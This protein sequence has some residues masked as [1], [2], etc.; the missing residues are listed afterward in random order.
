M[1][2]ASDHLA[3]IP[4][5]SG[6][7]DSALE[8]VA[9]L[10]TPA[11]VQ[12]GHVLVEHGQA[13]SGVFLIEAGEVEVDLGGGKCVQLGPGAFFGE[14]S[15]LTDRPRTARVQALTPTRLLAIGRQ[16]FTKLLETQPALALAMLKTLAERL[17]D[18][19]DSS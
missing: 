6:L 5:F 13:G 1:G 2:S 15:L 16:D 10:A 4:F 12:A 9:E 11:E 19:Q 3:E 18:A 8:A 14:L 17:I 7:P